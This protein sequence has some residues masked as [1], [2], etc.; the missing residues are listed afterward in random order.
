MHRMYEYMSPSVGSL[1]RR[2]KGFPGRIS[3]VLV[4]AA[5]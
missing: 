2:G 1:L 5:P 3:E 4:S